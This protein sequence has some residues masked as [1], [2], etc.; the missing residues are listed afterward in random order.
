MTIKGILTETQLSTLKNLNDNAQNLG[1]LQNLVNISLLSQTGNIPNN[2]FYSSVGVQW[3]KSFS[4][5]KVTNIGTSAFAFCTNLEIVKL[6]IVF[7]FVVWK[8]FK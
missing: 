2:C 5:P 1:V 4:A 3:L 6:C 7:L 8:I